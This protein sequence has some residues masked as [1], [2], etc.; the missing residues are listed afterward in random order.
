M[1]LFRLVT[2]RSI[3][4]EK[5]T[6]VIVD[7]Y[8]RYTWVY[9]LKKKS[10]APETIMSFIK[11]VE[12]QNGIHVKQLRTDNEAARTML[13]G[14]VFSKKYWAEV[15]ATACYTQNRSTIVKRHLKTPYEIFRGRLPNINFLHVFGCPVF[16]HNHKDHLVESNVVQFI[17]PYEKP[18]PIIT[19]AD[20][21]LDQSGQVVQSDQVSP[22][23]I[24]FMVAPTP[25][26]RWSRDKNI[27][28]VNIVGNPGMLTRVMAKELS[29]ASA[30]EF[31]Q[32]DVKSAF[33][34]GKLKE[35]VYVQQPPGISINQENYVKDLLKKYDINGSSVKSLM[36]PPNKVGSDLNGK[37]INKTQYRGDIELNFI[38]TQYQ[39]VDIFTKPLEEPTFKILIVEL[40]P[41]LSAFTNV[42]S[43]SA[44]GHDASADLMCSCA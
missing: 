26:D 20:A 31:Y 39:L 36:V 28:P 12:N 41:V 18:K 44:S 43:E 7:E 16:I 19:E 14:S 35:E 37:S 22:S 3:N 38:P 33:L 6:L 27:K 42:H 29:V 4:H 34:N 9:F 2:P 24:P 10:H 21:P 40:E 1:D 23:S 11:R 5:Y 32:M 30:H 13:S 15:I 8:S 25:Q 17:E